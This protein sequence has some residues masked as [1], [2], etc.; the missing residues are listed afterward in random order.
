MDD[1]KK[2]KKRKDWNKE[3]EKI[4]MISAMIG[5]GKKRYKKNKIE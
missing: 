2:K 3:N 5:K 4:K 1:Y